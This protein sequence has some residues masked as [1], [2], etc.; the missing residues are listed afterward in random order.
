MPAPPPRSV[1]VLGAGIAGAAAARAFARRGC[2][3]TVVAPGGVADG[4]SAV[5]AA[6]VRPR[7]WRGTGQAVP[8]AEI[9]G[10]AFRWTSRWLRE[11]ETHH[12]RPCGVLLCAVDAD[13]EVQVRRRA[14][15]PATADVVQWC[16]A[17]EASDHAGVALPF[18]A[19]WVPSGGCVDLGGLVRE[20][21]ESGRV[22]V[23]RQPDA[24]TPDLVVDARARVPGGE[25]VRGQA[26]GVALGDAAART[27]VCT[28]GYMCPPGDDG[29]TWLGST[30]DRNDDATDERPSDDHRV[31]RRFDG[32]P[33][34]ADALRDAPT[35]RRFVAVRA[36]TPH[37]IAQVGFAS[38]GRAMTLGHGSRGAVTGPWAGELLAAA[39]F[40]ETLPATPA[41]WARLQ[42]RAS[43]RS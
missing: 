22:Q 20:L 40:G 27:V 24:T 34:L 6:A 32:L 19:A 35:V 12:F 17:S 2:E 10:D 29:L 13:D 39:A 4:A 28:N 31:R 1:R 30:Y 3:V 5:P 7:L 43:A 21:L 23:C 36:S 38:P 11:I 15:N 41:Q 37:R 42:A 26:L 18:G 33:A 14:L 16:E 25:I 9:V 8:D